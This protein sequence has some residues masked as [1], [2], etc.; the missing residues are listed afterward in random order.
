MFEVFYDG[1]CPLCMREIRFL[2]KRDRHHAI[3]FTDIAAPD[4]DPTPL[5]KTFEDFMSKIHGRL[6]DG[7]FVEGVDVFRN[8]YRAIGFG[9]LSTFSGFPGIAQIADAAYEIFARNR[10]RLTG[11]AACE[12]NRCAR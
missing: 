4:F 6:P 11:R 8:L 1:D 3:K 9:W 12:G 5:G 2:K 10:L 7:T